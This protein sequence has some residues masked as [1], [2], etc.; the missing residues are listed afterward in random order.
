MEQRYFLLLLKITV[1][2]FYT[3]IGLT[4]TILISDK[5]FIAHVILSCHI[6]CVG[7][8]DTVVTRKNSDKIFISTELLYGCRRTYDCQNWW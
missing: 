5:T 7:L 8:E 1:V 3:N 2:K 4:K 6:C